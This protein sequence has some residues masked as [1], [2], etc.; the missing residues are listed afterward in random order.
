MA[1]PLGEAGFLHFFHRSAGGVIEAAKWI[2]TTAAQEQ[3]R[4]GYGSFLWLLC[5][6]LPNAVDKGRRDRAQRPIPKRHN[7]DWARLC[8]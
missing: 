3:T 6:N 4:P 5:Q 7:A 1:R 8:P 2:T